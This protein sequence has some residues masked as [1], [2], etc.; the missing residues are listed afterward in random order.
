MFH[1]KPFHFLSFQLLEQALVI[2][3]Q[4]RKAARLNPLHF[5]AAK[6]ECPAATGDA[7]AD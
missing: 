5:E 4:I 1:L 7:E 2:E 3:E 6:A